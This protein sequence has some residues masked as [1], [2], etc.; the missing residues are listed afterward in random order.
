MLSVICR[1]RLTVLII[2]HCYQE[3]SLVL[4]RRRRSKGWRTLN[5]YFA[6]SYEA[7]ANT[8]FFDSLHFPIAEHVL[9]YLS[10]SAN[11]INP[12][13]LSCFWLFLFLHGGLPRFSFAICHLPLYYRAVVCEKRT[14]H[15]RLVIYHSFLLLIENGRSDTTRYKI[16]N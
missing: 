15:Q 1:P 13:T 12:M 5:A 16:K 8:T 4:W 3:M 2:Q 6:K 14:V 11:S 9:Y 10:S 7:G